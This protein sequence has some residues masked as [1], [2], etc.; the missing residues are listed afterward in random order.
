FGLGTAGDPIDETTVNLGVKGGPGCPAFA[1]V[2][3]TTPTT[4]GH[5]CLKAHIEWADDSN[6]NNNVGQENTDVVQ[7]ASPAQTT[8]RLRN[9]DL[10]R[11]RRYRFEV[12]TYTIPE[13]EPCGK[14]E[15]PPRDDV[16]A[17]TRDA[18]AVGLV[19]LS[20]RV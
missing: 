7:T 8:F 3:W 16:I 4:P 11:R 10:E 17:R 1:T 2:Q 18:A 9:D 12:D 5:Y 14:T 6:P 19:A 15:P 20:R 13:Q